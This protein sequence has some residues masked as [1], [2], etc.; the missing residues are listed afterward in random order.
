MIIHGNE[1]TLKEAITELL[2]VYRLND[3]LTEAQLIKSWETTAGSYVAKFT[4]HISIRNGVM[5]I[6]ISSPALK[7]E[8]S[9]ARNEL[10]ETL[11]TKAKKKVIKD[12]IFL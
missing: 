5:Y 11:N 7:N 9:Y 3:G 10:L 2:N 8:L 6:K 1:H 12:I 4:E